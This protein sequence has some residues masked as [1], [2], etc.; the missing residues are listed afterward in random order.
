MPIPSPHFRVESRVTFFFLSLGR[1]I[2][3]TVSNDIL[4][5]YIHSFGPDTFG[6]P[7]GGTLFDPSLP[8]LERYR[9]SFLL[10][11]CAGFSACFGIA[12]VYHLH[13]A[14]FTLLFQ[15]YPSQ[16]PPFF[17][18]PLLST[19][20]TNFW[21]TRWH[22]LFR[23]SFVEVGS[24]PLEIYFGRVGRIFGAFAV[25][26]AL[27]DVGMRGMGRGADTLEVVGFFFL[28]AVGMNLEYAWKKATDKN[29]GGI[30]GF[31]WTFF[32]LLVTGSIFMDASAKKGVLAARPDIWR[33]AASFLNWISEGYDC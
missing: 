29:V 16:W 23:E 28:N 1:V 17:D 11:L 22:Q 18:T 15:Q 25:S 31:L 30:I 6:T 12:S 2:L 5:G 26:A 20:L 8:P 3:F 27:H 14:L 10:T 33:L 24:K 9:N 7:K 32:F 4:L 21:G 13:A 19:S